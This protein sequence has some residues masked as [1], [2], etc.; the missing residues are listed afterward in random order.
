MILLDSRVGSRELLPYLQ[1]LGVL[2]ELTSLE[3][4]DAAFLGKGPTG[5]IAVGVERKTLHDILACVDDSRYGGHQRVGMAQLY[6]ACFLLIEGIWRPHD[7]SGVLMEGF[8]GGASWGECR[9]RTQRVAYSKL[10]RYLFSVSLSGVH[11]LYTRDLAHTAY[12]V[13]ELFHY[14]Q[15]PWRDHTS[16][17]ETQ[18]LNL[19]TLQH[20]PSLTRLWASSIDGVGVK[21]G[22]EAER[23]FRKPITLATAD[24]SQWLRLNHVGVSTAQAIVRQIQGVTR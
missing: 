5:D 20:R 10:R 3:F 22:E 16:L 9:Y 23:L 17:R 15:K 14:F 8:R 11:V 6:Q 19:P 12:D 18:K 21:L 24:E 13:H 2:C 1:K 7:P 4:G